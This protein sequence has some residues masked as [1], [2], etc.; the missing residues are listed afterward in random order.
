VDR[1]GEPE[2]SDESDAADPRRFTGCAMHTHR[3]ATLSPSAHPHGNRS[4]VSFPESGN[5]H[6]A[7]N[8]AKNPVSRAREDC[9]RRTMVLPKRTSRAQDWHA[10]QVDAAWGNHR[11]ERYEQSMSDR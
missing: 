2:A 5:A 4:P 10:S 1:G 11:Q 7:K 9:S 3:C 6:D 8:N